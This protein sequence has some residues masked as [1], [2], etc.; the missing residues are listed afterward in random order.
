MAADKE[1]APQLGN[2][3][4]D[5]AKAGGRGYSSISVAQILRLQN[6]REWVRPKWKLKSAFPT[7]T[8]GSSSVGAG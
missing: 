6:R 5:D 8:S 7:E 4:T 2:M 1:K 3:H